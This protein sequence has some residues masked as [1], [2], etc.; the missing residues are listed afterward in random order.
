MN[1][2]KAA[3]Q[4]ADDVADGGALGRRNESDAA[5]KKRQWFFVSGA[6]KAFGFKTFL[7]LLEGDLQRAA[8]G[9][10]H[11]LDVNLVFAARLVNADAAANRNFEAV[12]R[13]ELHAAHLLFEPDAADLGFFVLECEVEVA[14]L[15]FT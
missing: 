2:V 11:G 14:G 12:F 10:L 5:G 9:R 6:K 8:A 7:E 13:T 15:G 4:D 3:P 1:V